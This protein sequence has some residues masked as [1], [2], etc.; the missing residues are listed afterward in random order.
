MLRLPQAR[1][2][3]QPRVGLQNRV[4]AVPSADGVDTFLLPLHAEASSVQYLAMV[5]AP[6]EPRRAALWLWILATLSGAAVALA[7]IERLRH[8]RIVMTDAI[9]RHLQLGVLRIEGASIIE[10]NDR[11]EEFLRQPLPAIS[12]GQNS[13]PLV[14]VFNWERVYVDKGRNADGPVRSLG[15]LWGLP[16][17][18]SGEGK[19]RS[20]EPRG[21]EAPCQ[22]SSGSDG[23]D[24]RTMALHRRTQ[25]LI[26]VLVLAMSLVIYALGLVLLGFTVPWLPGAYEY[27][28]IPLLMVLLTLG[29]FLVVR[30][31]VPPI[32]QSYH[33]P[34]PLV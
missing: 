30:P 5:P 34:K 7:V 27:A 12:S 28:H 17:R 32:A 23:G 6:K 1:A 10:A 15:D 33:D 25:W 9:L 19:S 3:R 26:A 8:Q 29:L 24:A 11:A 4:A 16:M 21:W 18:L 13:V 20:R 14:N 2:A 31:G 22:R